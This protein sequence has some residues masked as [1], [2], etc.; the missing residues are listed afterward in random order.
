M[1]VKYIPPV[2]KN[3][4]NINT[5]SLNEFES[6]TEFRHTNEFRH[7]IRLHSFL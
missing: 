7:T 3:I 5:F 2:F 4:Y 1:S 6:A